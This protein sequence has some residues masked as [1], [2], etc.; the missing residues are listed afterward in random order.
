MPRFLIPSRVGLLALIAIYTESLVPSKAIVPILSFLC[1]HVLAKGLPAESG[2]AKH[3]GFVVGIEGLQRATLDQASGTPGRTIWDVLLARL[4]NINCLSALHQSFDDLSFLLEKR[5]ETLG[6]EKPDP[7]PK[8][9]PLSP[10]SPL[11]LFVRR[12]QVEFTR[13][14]FLDGIALWTAFVAYREPTLLQWKKRNP[15][16][17]VSSFDVNLPDKDTYSDVLTDLLY[18]K[19]ARFLRT[20]YTISTGDVERLLQIQVER[21]Q[22][23]STSQN[24]SLCFPD[25]KLFREGEQTANRGQ[26]CCP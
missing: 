13:L 24:P 1:S 12:A 15:T 5:A 17:G 9:I 16:A 2:G 18:P 23:M 11:G 21:M 3:E 4:W 25:R 20:R 8:R 6:R 10:H 19:N 22:S 7:A 14:P 26:D